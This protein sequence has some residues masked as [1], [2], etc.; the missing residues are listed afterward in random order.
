[1]T[2]IA[3]PVRSAW[4]FYPWFIAGGLGFVI[5]V[6]MVM[7]YIALSTFPG[8]AAVDKPPANVSAHKMTAP[9]K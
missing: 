6:N 9:P 8:V 7:V 2:S 3:L 1:M 5:V 4:R